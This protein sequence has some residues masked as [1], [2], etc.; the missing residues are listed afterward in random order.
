MPEM[1]A[2]AI[3]LFILFGRFE[4]ALKRS[5]FLRPM[6]RRKADQA[7]LAG[8]DWGALAVALG[9]EFFQFH[10]DSV[11]A[12]AIFEIAP[13]LAIARQVGDDPPKYELDWE[14]T[15]IPKNA[16]DLIGAVQRI[17]NN[18]FHGD[19]SNPDHARNLILVRAAC[20][21]LVDAHSRIKLNPLLAN[22]SHQ[23]E[24]FG[25]IEV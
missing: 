23:L 7:P 19:K 13:R 24:Y 9:A 21:I 14:A 4:Y 15:A 3:K 17:R 2:D 5:D 22:L 25:P 12:Q 8:A 11:S 16:S 18:L 20:A 1:H 10:R 6:K